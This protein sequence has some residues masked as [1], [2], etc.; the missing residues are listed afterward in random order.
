M[1]NINVQHSS[2]FL[3]LILITLVFINSSY[4]ADVLDISSAQTSTNSQ[5]NTIGI[6][7]VVFEEVSYA[8]DVTLYTDGTW[9]ASNVTGY[10]LDDSKA[11][12][13]YKTNIILFADSVEISSVVTDTKGTYEFTV[14]VK[15]DVIA[16]SEPPGRVAEHA[17]IEIL[18]LWRE[19]FAEDPNTVFFY[20][21]ANGVGQA[22]AI[23]MFEPQFNSDYTVMT[24][25]GEL[26]NK[27]D[28][29]SSMSLNNVSIMIDPT[30]WK[31]VKMGLLCGGA[32]VAD[33]VAVFGDIAA[34]LSIIGTG[35]LNVAGGVPIIALLTGSGITVSIACA[36]AIGDLGN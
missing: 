24:F 29:F 36:E 19:L 14:Q 4:A 17:P 7:N 30:V 28:D 22:V 16:F 21:D 32:V 18:D 2:I 11:T 12:G 34:I 8:A 35:G 6:Q 23:H 1:K 5:N 25:K 27:D 9:G 20:N 10:S 26:L 13:Q 31:W 33:I 3:W 15:K